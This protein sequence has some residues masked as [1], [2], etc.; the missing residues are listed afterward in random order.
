MSKRFLRFDKPIAALIQI[1]VMN[2]I[3]YAI[4][5]GSIAA[6]GEAIPL[7][8]ISLLHLAYY[9]LQLELMG[10]CFGISAFLLKGSIGVGLGIAVMMYFLNLIANIADVAEF[11]K[12]ITPFG[13]CEGADIIANGSLDISLV[14][15]GA[16]IGISGIIVAYMKYTTKDIH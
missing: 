16:V 7:K 6:V 4:V 11:L 9:L 1:T 3:I 15:I 14:A 5:I 8:E 12:Y 13:Y 10:I 2:I